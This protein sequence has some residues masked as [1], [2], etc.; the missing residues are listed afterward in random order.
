MLS[1]MTAS[2]LGEW[3]DHF[4]RFSFSD[5]LLDAE[6]CDAE[7]AGDRAGDR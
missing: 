3:A 6:F 4:V 5:A 1:E 2:E 7:S